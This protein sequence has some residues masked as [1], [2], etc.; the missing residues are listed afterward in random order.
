MISRSGQGKRCA[1]KGKTAPNAVYNG[2]VVRQSYYWKFIAKVRRWLV[3]YRR[4]DFPPSNG[5]HVFLGVT[6]VDHSPPASNTDGEASQPGPRLR[7]RGPRSEEARGRRLH[8]NLCR[9]ARSKSTDSHDLSVFSSQPVLTILH[10]NI[11]GLLG[12]T[13]ELTARL[14]LL[15]PKPMLICITES[16]L[17]KSIGEVMLEGY[18]LVGRHDRQD[19]RKCGGVVMYALASYANYITL[20]DKSLG[21]ERLWAVVHSDLGPY[22]VGLW[23]RPPVQGEMETIDTL[24]H[25]WSKYSGKSSAPLLLA[26]STSITKSGSGDQRTTV[27]KVNFY[28]NIVSL[29]DCNSWCMNRRAESICR[30]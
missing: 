7:R 6:D 25:E 13:T 19:G 30:I 28:T 10:V 11:R 27:R 9:H 8:R 3:R 2:S 4:T 26:I 20:L 14:R 17:D 24:H 29:Q 16:W 5:M 23:Y 22:L 12:H 1:G 15:P 21:A 18:V